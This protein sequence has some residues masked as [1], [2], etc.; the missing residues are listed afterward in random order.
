MLLFVIKMVS[1]LEKATPTRIRSETDFIK[2]L[3][4][5][6]PLNRKDLGEVI[7]QIPFSFPS[8]ER[9]IGDVFQGNAVLIRYKDVDGFNVL[10]MSAAL[11]KNPET[12]LMEKNKQQ[13]FYTLFP[14]PVSEQEAKDA[15][16]GLSRIQ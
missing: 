10:I 4:E 1:E 16:D 2:F 14:E 8:G 12:L 13:E 15:Y 6:I 3:R 11:T 7:G 9:R 5:I